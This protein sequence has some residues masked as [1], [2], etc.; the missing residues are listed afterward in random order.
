MKLNTLVISILALAIITAIGCREPGPSPDNTDNPNASTS[1]SAP[2]EGTQK[3]TKKKSYGDSQLRIIESEFA[4]LKQSK[5]LA[6]A[7]K[8]GLNQ[9]FAQRVTQ[10]KDWY[11][12]NGPKIVALRKE[13]LEAARRKDLRKLKEMNKTGSKE[14][15]SNLVNQERKLLD[16]YRVELEKQIP[17]EAKL[18]WQ[19]TIVSN[20]LLE[21]LEPL[22]LTENQME[23]V[24]SSASQ[25]IARLGRKQ[26]DNWRGYGTAKLE[27]IFATKHLEASQK[28]AFEQLQKSNKMRMMKWG[29]KF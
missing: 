16:E 6:P 21:F 24:R 20:Q 12:K 13:A 4:I 3:T 25:A 7:E 14:S 2:D 29:Q 23:Q 8:D 10:I 15:V 19:S 11:S 5:Q 1:H 9:F 17:K 18:E 28:Q 27:E 22:Q 26:Q